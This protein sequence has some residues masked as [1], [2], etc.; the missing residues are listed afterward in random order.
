MTIRARIS[1]A[2]LTLKGE[3][4]ANTGHALPIAPQQAEQNT[5]NTVSCS[6]EQLVELVRVG[7]SQALLNCR[8]SLQQ[9]RLADIRKTYK[10]RTLLHWAVLENQTDMAR[11]LLLQGP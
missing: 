11:H 3:Y 4:R 5:A 8:P 2:T 10:G 9:L 1:P 6:F 7:A